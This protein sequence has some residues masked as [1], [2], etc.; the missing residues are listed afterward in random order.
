[1]CLLHHV[2]LTSEVVVVEA[3]GGDDGAADAAALLHYPTSPYQSD[4]DT[5]WRC[6]QLVT[7]IWCVL[8]RQ[9]GWLAR[10]WC[11]VDASSTPVAGSVQGGFGAALYRHRGGAR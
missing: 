8:S 7:S 9:V 6:V 5:T 11:R 2:Q 10:Q 1:M 3:G 4:P